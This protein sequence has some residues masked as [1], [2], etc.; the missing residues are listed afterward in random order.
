MAPRIKKN[1][2]SV[3]QKEHGIPKFEILPNLRNP[4]VI[5]IKSN[6]NFMYLDF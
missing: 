1:Y 4:K 5:F 3:I 2:F 6:L